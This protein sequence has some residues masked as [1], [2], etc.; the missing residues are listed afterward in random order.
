MMMMMMM[1]MMMRDDDDGEVAVEAFF[2]STKV[3]NIPEFTLDRFLF[4]GRQ[5]QS[6]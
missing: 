6:T 3:V 2:P 4:G 5:Q 1:M